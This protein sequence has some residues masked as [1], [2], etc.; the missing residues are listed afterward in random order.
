MDYFHGW[1]ALW[2]AS[3]L[4]CGLHAQDWKVASM[5]V[6]VSNIWLVG[7]AVVRKLKGVV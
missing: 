7:G 6:I 2:L 1:A 4:L 3:G 5:F